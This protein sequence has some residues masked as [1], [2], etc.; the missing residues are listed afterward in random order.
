M[1]AAQVLLEPGDSNIFRALEAAIEISTRSVLTLPQ[2][3]RNSSL[4]M[5]DV[6]G[7]VRSVCVVVGV[8][9]RHA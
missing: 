7:S 6:S 8:R 4:K 9:R 5:A 3:T 2:Q 1:H